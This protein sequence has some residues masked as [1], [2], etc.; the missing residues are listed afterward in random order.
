MVHRSSESNRGASDP[1]YEPN[2]ISVRFASSLIV[3]IVV[4]VIAGL[5]LMYVYYQFLA[6]RAAAAEDDNLAHAP[7]HVRQQSVEPRLTTDGPTQLGV[8]RSRI[9]IG[10]AMDLLVEQGPSAQDGTIREREKASTAK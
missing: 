6:G 10:R 2:Q 7:L 3:G 4:I 9:P 8:L 1:G 5:C